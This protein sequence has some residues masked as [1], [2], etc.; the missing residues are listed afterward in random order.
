MFI[1]PFKISSWP[2]AVKLGISPVIAL[3]MTAFIAMVGVNG[4][5]R[6]SQSLDRVVHDA[7]GGGGL[8]MK[9]ENE[10]QAVNGGI[11][12]VLALQAAKT[13]GLDA[14]TELKRLSIQV[15]SAVADL[16]QYRDG[17][18]T[19]ADKPKFDKLIKD[20]EKYKGAITWV[21]QMM[22]IDFNSA[23]SF[24]VPLDNNYSELNT[25][26]GA[27][28]AAGQ[29]MSAAQ[30]RDANAVAANTQDVFIK[31]AV[32]AGFVVLAIGFMVGWGTTRSIHDIAG[33]TRNLA[34]G[35]LKID[36]AHLERRDEL[37][38][39]VQ[40]LQVF[41]DTAILARERTEQAERTAHEAEQAIKGVGDGLDALAK[42]DLTH[43]ITSQFTGPFVKLKEDFNAAVARLNE[44]MRTVLDN[45]DTINNGAVAISEAAEDLSKRTEKQSANLQCTAAAL[46]EIT[47]TVKTTA[48]NAKQ[49]SG[50][51]NKTKQAAETGSQVVDT[52]IDAID[53]IEESSKRITEIISVIDEISFQTNLLALN[54]GVE[55]ARAGDAGKGFAVVASEVRALA[56]RSSQAGKE[57]KKLIQD[58]SAHVAAGVNH[59]RESG[60]VLGDIMGQIGQINT[61]VEEIAQGAQQQSAGVEEV[62]SSLSEVGQIT[63]EN[64]AMVE[65]TTASAHDLAEGTS[66]LSSLISFFQVEAATDFRERRD[67]A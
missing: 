40:S 67:A 31:V 39:I 57:I 8:L 48:Q 23:V 63:Q 29:Q 54:A 20:V 53:R 4:V 55:A 32:A 11:Y 12:R 56:Q 43:R 47:A 51:V 5:N 1:N 34:R 59:V 36:V 50:I 49:T 19:A 7:V 9:A 26:I 10:I 62:N 3:V 37:N 17:W 64:S 35:D 66:Q 28:I 33:A 13:A 18:A 27:I 6:Q 30:E 52:A 60:K 44:T 65:H 46:E 61:L 41:R 45:A 25:E 14:A 42:G 38:A 58:S 24:L 16:K 15:D 21:S 2:F 22:E